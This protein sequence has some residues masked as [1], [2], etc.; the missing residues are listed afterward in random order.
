MKNS[1]NIIDYNSID[2]YILSLHSVSKSNDSPT[3][4]YQKSRALL[5]ILPTTFLSD[6]A[7]KKYTTLSSYVMSGKID[8]NDLHYIV[9]NPTFFEGFRTH[10]VSTM[11]S[12][13]D[14]LKNRTKASRPSITFDSL[15]SLLED[16]LDT[17]I[18]K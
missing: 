4:F 18:D 6:S 15:D 5:S 1:H 7:D 2:N 10:I 17:T 11:E 12:D 3:L 8:I 14:S 16:S 13:F 9:D